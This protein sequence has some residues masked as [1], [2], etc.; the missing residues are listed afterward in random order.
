MNGIKAFYVKKTGRKVPVGFEIHHIDFNRENNDISNLVALPK[1]VHRDYHKYSDRYNDGLKPGKI[2][3]LDNPAF[4][5]MFNE[6]FQM[7]V[8]NYKIACYW[9]HFRNTLLMGGSQGI[10]GC[11]Y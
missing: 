9:V 4:I 11:S 5:E 8:E 3:L 10:Y 6:N 1:K 2:L 7:L